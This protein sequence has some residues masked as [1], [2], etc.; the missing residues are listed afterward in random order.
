M[1]LVS[2]QG[3]LQ[4][5]STLGVLGLVAGSN[6]FLAGPG[7]WSTSHADLVVGLNEFLAGP[8]VLTH[9]VGLVAH[10]IRTTQ[11]IQA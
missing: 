1:S 6:E 9:A 3:V 7:W 2:L 11:L 8:G 5:F 4:Q 10:G